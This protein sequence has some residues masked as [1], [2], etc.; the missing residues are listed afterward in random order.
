MG[1]SSCSKEETEEVAAV[2]SKLNKAY[3]SDK[4]RAKMVFNPVAA[5]TGPEIFW[6]F[7]GL[8]WHSLMQVSGF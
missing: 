4:N 8:G 3:F 2:N 7:I 1:R 6:N 5:L